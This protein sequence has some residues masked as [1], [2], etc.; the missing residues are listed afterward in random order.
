MNGDDGF[1]FTTPRIFS[2]EANVHVARIKFADFSFITTSDGV[3][4]IDAGTSE[5]RVSN[6][7]ADLG[8]ARTPVSHL[9]ITHAHPDHL[10]GTAALRGPSTQVITQ[11]GFPAEQ[12][13]QRHHSALPF[14]YYFGNVPS[15]RPDITPD[16]LIG[17]PTALTIGGTELVLYPTVAAKPLTH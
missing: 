9:I 3:I 15:A 6:A 5:Q 12:D 1:R 10:G 17:E 8:Q 11:A 13:R 4:A 7:L 2:P 16:R 14:R